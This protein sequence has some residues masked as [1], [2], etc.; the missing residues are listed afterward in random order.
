MKDK[1]HI[2]ISINAGKAFDKSQHPFMIKTLQ[3]MGIEDTYLNIV[4]DI[5]DKPTA[6]FILN[7]EKQ[8]AIPLRP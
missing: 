2:I 7:V 1:N 5:Y 4:K 8:K 6:N 3:R